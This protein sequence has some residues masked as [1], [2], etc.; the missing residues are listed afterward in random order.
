MKKNEYNKWYLIIAIFAVIFT[1]F[2]GSLAYWQWTTNETERTNIALTV[3]E[4]FRCDA[5]GGGDISSGEKYLVPTD[6]TNADYA[7][8]RTITVSS[9]LFTNQLD[10]SLDLWLTINSISD[11]LKNSENFKYVVSTN[12]NSCTEGIVNSGTFKGKSVGSKVS[13]LDSK[14]YLDSATETY[15]LYVWLDKAETSTATMDQE[16]SLSLGGDC[17]SAIYV[18]PEV[19]VLD[20][21]MVPIKLSNAGVATVADTSS[22]WY[23]YANKEWANVV[24]VNE[25]ATN[26]IEG[27]YSREYYLNNPGTTVL[28]SDI[29]AY[30]VWIPRYKY[31]IWTTSI[32]AKGK[33]QTINI[34]FEDKDTS[35]SNGNAVGEYLTH[36]AF[37]FGDEELAGIWIG[38]FETTG[39]TT[40][41]TIKPNVQ[42]LRNQNVSTYFQISLKFSGGIMDT[43]NGAVT[44]AGSSTYGLTN[45]TNSHM[46]KNKDWGAVTYLS[47][48]IYGINKEIYANNSLEYTGRSGGNTGESVN[49]VYKQFGSGSTSESYNRYGY[50]TWIGQSIASNG[51]I[52]EIINPLLGTNASTTGNIT[53]I[54]DMVGG[55]YE[56]VMGMLSDSNGNPRSGTSITENSGFNGIIYDDGANNIYSDGISFPESKYYDLYLESQFN[57]TE[58]TNISLCTLETCGGQALFETNKWYNAQNTFANLDGPWFRRGQPAASLNNSHYSYTDIFAFADSRGKSSDANSWRSILIVDNGD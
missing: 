1:F 48:S 35:K 22:E 25:N 23:N 54:Y 29:L 6:C 5:D 46:V 38:K 15:Y 11:G 4:D 51:T 33:E 16:F 26:G 50:Y 52:G 10:V 39:D 19:P 2:G 31:Q 40:T 8:Q 13:L 36:P 56:S 24:L 47:H 42:S 34:I 27:S 30:Y 55:N 20:D 32:S 49:K 28:E 58:N 53:G 43:S 14:L 17:E 44:F 45:K 18:E 12:S 57:G 3:K 37:T 21:G 7:I 41:P 9:T